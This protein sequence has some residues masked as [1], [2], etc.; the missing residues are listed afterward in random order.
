M[1]TEEVK[2][3][4]C[5]DHIVWNA[6]VCLL[7]KHPEENLHD[8]ASPPWT[9]RDVYAHLAR[10]LGHSNACIEACCAGRELPQLEA[11]PLEM[12]TR[13]QREDSRMGLDEARQRAQDAFC[14]RMGI[15]EAIPLSKWDDNLKRMAR[16]D[17]A[18]HYAKHINYIVVT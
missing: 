3:M 14:R 6:L 15:I 10:W 8:P 5:T 16:Y 11:P 13:W 1:N 18:W 2:A 9:S 12:N 17:G 7:E 4:L